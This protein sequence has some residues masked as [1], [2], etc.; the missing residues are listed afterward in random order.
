MAVNTS[1]ANPGWE[2]LIESKYCCS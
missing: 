1:K 2:P